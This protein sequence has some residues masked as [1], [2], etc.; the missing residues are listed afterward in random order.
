MHQHFK[1]NLMNIAFAG[2]IIPIQ[3]FS[4]PGGQPV[5]CA[6]TYYKNPLLIPKFNEIWLDTNL[7]SQTGHNPNI[8]SL[9]DFAL[10]NKYHINPIFAIAEFNRGHDAI[11]MTDMMLNRLPAMEERYGF[12]FFDLNQVTYQ[13]A[14]LPGVKVDDQ[15]YV[16][17]LSDFMIVVKYFYSRSNW[18]FEMRLTAYAKLVKSSL[19]HVAI[20]FY[21]ASLYYFAKE[22]RNLFE[23][24]FPK[25][26]EAMR[27]Y[28]S[29][30]SNRKEANNLASDLALFTQTTAAPVTFNPTM[31]RVPYIATSDIGLALL[32]Q[33]ICYF[34]INV[35]G[36]KGFG[37]PDLRID[38]I[39]HKHAFAAVRSIRDEHLLDLKV[40]PERVQVL[41][42]IAEKILAG[43]FDHRKL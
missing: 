36:G 21:V 8:A 19:P 43:N 33:E 23:S 38:G 9:V 14:R 27:D 4:A 18:N 2:N 41:S 28:G 20:V 32:L 12:P 1:N 7:V 35:K 3:T 29:P 30:E 10:K 34:G 11:T 16:K 26:Q 42:E 17:L 6:S 15:E 24:S 37:Y 13:T 25:V 40:Q 31:F 39:M 5:I 22:N